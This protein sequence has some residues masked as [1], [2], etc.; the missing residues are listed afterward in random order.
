[1]TRVVLVPG[2]PALLP[3]HAGLHDPVADLRAACRAAVAS[4]G[5]EVTVRASS[6]QG[7]RVAAHLLDDVARTADQPSVLLVGNGSA[8]RTEKAPGHLDPRAAGF[9]RDLRA[10]LGG[11]GAPP[12]AGVARELWADVD[13]LLAWEGGF[14][15]PEV[16]YED[17]PYGVMYW[18]LGWTR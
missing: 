11:A 2:V 17:D 4:L 16:Y 9:D 6:S 18:V 7:E 1:M 8:C 14:G 12:D 10:W 5:S 3:E 15:A 13:A